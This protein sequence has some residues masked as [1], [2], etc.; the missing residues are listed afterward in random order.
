ME[1]KEYQS[2]VIPTNTEEK[3][4]VAFSHEYASANSNQRAIFTDSR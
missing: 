2:I 1:Q 3:K 4:I